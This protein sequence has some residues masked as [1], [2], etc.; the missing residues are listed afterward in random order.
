MIRMISMTHGTTGLVEDSLAWTV[1]IDWI[2]VTI[3]VRTGVL[4]EGLTE[5]ILLTIK[6]GHPITL[7]IGGEVVWAEAEED[8]TGNP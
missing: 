6:E 2:G 5:A 1:P 3:G 4:I 8:M 7:I